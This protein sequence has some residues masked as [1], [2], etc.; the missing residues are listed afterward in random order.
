MPLFEYECKGCG[1]KFELLKRGDETPRCPSCGGD[2]VEKCLS[3][4]AVSVKSGSPAPASAGA[5]AA[6]PHASGPAGCGMAH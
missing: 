2:Q 3:V 4:F 1:N 5:C 6:C